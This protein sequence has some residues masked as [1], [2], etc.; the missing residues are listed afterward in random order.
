[1]PPSDNKKISVILPP[2]LIRQIEES[3][4]TQTKAVIEALNYYFS[5]DRNQIEVYKNQIISDAQKIAILEA[6]LV[7]AEAHRMT[8]IREL[9]QVHSEYQAH[10]GQVQ[11]LIMHAEKRRLIEG[12]RRWWKFW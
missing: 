1:M 8:L 9:E 6:R 10:I 4:L 7:E 3:G 11:V 12:K 2:D 5:E